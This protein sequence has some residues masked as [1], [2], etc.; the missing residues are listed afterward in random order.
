MWR[1]SGL[2]RRLELTGGETR[3]TPAIVVVGCW[4]PACWDVGLYT[5]VDCRH[6]ARTIA[7]VD[8]RNSRIHS[9]ADCISE[10]TVKTDESSSR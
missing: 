8:I 3:C 7:F 10:R 5:S 6:E 1:E 2:G 9:R 4:R